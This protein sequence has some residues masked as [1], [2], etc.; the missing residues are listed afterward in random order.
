MSAR[1]GE[2]I[3]AL[4]GRLSELVPRPDVPVTILV[5][6]DHGEVVSKVHQHGDVAEVSHTADGTRMVA[7]LPAWL[8]GR[9]FGVPYVVIGFRGG[10][11]AIAAI[12]LFASVYAVAPISAHAGAVGRPLADP[13][14]NTRPSASFVKACRSMGTGKAANVRCDRAAAKS[15]DKVWKS[16]GIKNKLVL[17]QDFATLSVADQ[18]LAITDVERV[19]RGRR[20]V[21]G[22]TAKENALA[23]AGA[24]HDRD[25]GFPTP[26]P[27]TSG[28]A[29]WAGAGTSALL[30][31]FYWMYD[32]GP[33]S[34]NGD[35]TAAEQSG[36]WGHRHNVIGRY[37]AP[38]RDGSRVGT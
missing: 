8:A 2:G 15:F 28:G 5:P 36:C 1:T 38:H 9:G 22:L 13:P 17:P 29:N 11:G 37:D 35:C 32:D 31:D 7:R 20:P 19:A 6:F 27:G 23:R 3:E 24:K 30:D 16:E 34:Q 4:R 25:P 12:A 14:K 10:L 26:F 33:G 21:K 18:L